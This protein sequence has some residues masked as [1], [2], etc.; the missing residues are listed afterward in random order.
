MECLRRSARLHKLHVF[1]FSFIAPSK[2]QY[3]PLDEAAKDSNKHN[4]LLSMSC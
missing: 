1:D 4:T 2:A 3:Q